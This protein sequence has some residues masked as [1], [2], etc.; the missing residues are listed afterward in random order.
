MSMTYEGMLLFAIAFCASLLFQAATEGQLDGW[1][2]PF[3][4]SYL[5]LVFGLYFLWHWMRGGQTLPMKTWKLRLVSLDGKD[6][7]AKQASI[8]YLA[9]WIS[10]LCL[11]AGF[12]WAIF[13]R[14]RQFLHDRL[15]GTRVI[16]T[17][18]N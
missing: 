12:L 5:F 18:R 14:D 15:A 7:R 11:G 16:Q 9:A 10:L 6:I 2:R 8:R 17:E 13:D 1:L 3:H 4:Q